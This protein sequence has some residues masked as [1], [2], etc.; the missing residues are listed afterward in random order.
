MT[1]AKKEA[2]QAKTKITKRV[3]SDG[4]DMWRSGVQPRV[5][6]NK[7][8]VT[9]AQFNWMKDEGDD[10][11]PSFESMMLKEVSLMRSAGRKAA[12]RL[13]QDCMEVLQL[14]AG[15]AK[16]ANE[17]MAS[18]LS[19]WKM[20]FSKNPETVDV[21]GKKQLALDLLMSKAEL[22]ALKVLTKISDISACGNAFV[23]IFGD[24]PLNKALYPSRDVAMVDQQAD[25][26]KALQGA[27]ADRQKMLP[28]ELQ[29]QV[30]DDVSNMSLE[31]LRKITGYEGG[32][33]EQ[34][35]V[36]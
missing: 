17:I 2:K 16:T 20:S 30:M 31:E 24:A 3:H 36:E 8:K 21:E 27:D 18:I 34:T 4:Y 13:G 7:L 9:S 35:N 23:R 29:E 12:T 5:I 28:M 15:N 1:I 22:E 14:N 6:I 32:E 11:F 25:P 26:L 33:V 19:R 10:K